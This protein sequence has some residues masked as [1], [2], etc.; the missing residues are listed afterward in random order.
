MPGG[1]GDGMG[2]TAVPGGDGVEVD[3]GLDGDRSVHLRNRQREML[4]AERAADQ[5]GPAADRGHRRA[6]CGGLDQLMFGHVAAR[7]SQ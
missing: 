1:S 6:E 4:R 2:S 5:L 3:A 7:V